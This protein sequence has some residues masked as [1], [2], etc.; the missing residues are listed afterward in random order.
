MFIATSL[1]HYKHLKVRQHIVAHAENKE[2]SVMYGL[3]KF[4]KRPD[5][6]TYENDVFE[7]AKKKATSFHCSEELWE[8]PLAIATGA[9]RK[10]LDALRIGW[11]LILDIDCPDWRLSKLTSHLFVKALQ[12]HGITA[13][14][15]K[16]S[17]NKGFHIAVPFESFPSQIPFEGQ[18]CLTKD[19]FPEGPRKIASYLLSYLTENCAQVLDQEQKVI[20]AGKHE[21]SFADFEAI[22]Q[23]NNKTLVAHQCVDCNKVFE[24]QKNRQTKLVYQCEQCGFINKPKGAPEL[25]R[26]EKCSYPVSSKQNRSS[27]GCPHCGSTNK[28]EPKFNLLAVVEVDTVLIASR[29]LY[30]MPYALHEKSGLVSV[31]IRVEDILTFEKDIAKPENISFTIPF[32]DRSLAVPGEGAQLLVRAFDDTYVPWEEEKRQTKII[33]V[34]TDAI[35]EDYFPPCIKNILAGLKD[36][37][38]RALFILVNF[39]RVSGWSAEQIKD[40][41]YTWNEQNPEPLKEQYLK[42]QLFQ[43]KKGKAPMPPP[44]C[45]NKDYYISLLV[46]KPDD[47]CPRIRNPAMYA[48]RKAEL[49]K[50]K[51]KKKVST[52][53]KKSAK[54]SLARAKEQNSTSQT[55]KEQEKNSKKE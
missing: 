16:F 55:Q 8:N 15:V 17:G 42:G 2:V 46:C 54:D 1:S 44:N 18:M 9:S 49:G 6:L 34:P 45:S 39:L 5:V 7:L 27:I 37:K 28:P 43:I 35:S 52:T 31:P 10:D 29:H 14:T 12:D 32:L 26:C 30:R 24:Q 47:F 25:I 21:F 4:G 22:L 11:D 20:F 40:F 33:D 36:G 13:A 41:V 51:S 38:K 19:L 50:K 3:A 53:T 48:K 23:K